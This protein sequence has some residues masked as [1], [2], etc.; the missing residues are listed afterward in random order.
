MPYFEHE[1]AILQT[2]YWI[3]FQFLA[4]IYQTF[5]FISNNAK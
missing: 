1:F 5:P 2:E 4:P 3:V